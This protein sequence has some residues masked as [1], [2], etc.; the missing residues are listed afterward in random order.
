MEL[1]MEASSS[2]LTDLS[3][4]NV[5]KRI[6]AASHKPQGAADARI[7]Q[8][9][10]D[11]LYYFYEATLL[12]RMLGSKAPHHSANHTAGKRSSSPWHKFLDEFS[13]LGDSELGGSS[14]IAI[15]VEEKVTGLHFWVA[16]NGHVKTKTFD[17]LTWLLEQLQKVEQTPHWNQ[18]YLVQQIFACSIDQ[19][20]KKVCNYARRLLKLVTRVQAAGTDDLSNSGEF[21]YIVCYKVVHALTSCRDRELFSTLEQLVAVH[22]DPLRLCANAYQLRRT[23]SMVQLSDKCLRDGDFSDWSLIRHYV[24]R[25]GSWMKAARTVVSFARQAPDVFRELQIEAVPNP[26]PSVIRWT[27]QLS[28]VEGVLQYLFPAFKSSPPGQSFKP[29]A[30]SY[31]EFVT[32]TLRYK[33]DQVEFRP[34]VH[35][36]AL[37]ADHFYRHDLRFVN[38]DRYIGCRQ[39][40][41][42]PC[43]GNTWIKW[44][45]PY[46]GDIGA[47]NSSL[48]SAQTLTHMMSDIGDDIRKRIMAGGE[49]GRRLPDSVT[50]LSTSITHSN[51]P[52]GGNALSRPVEGVL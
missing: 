42:R 22:A 19:S 39:F 51:E 48:I 37:I 6:L 40:V 18:Q 1:L 3:P 5:S 15:A 13:W 23:Q 35:A 47:R 24:G 20:R 9:S 38:Q 12:L 4:S 45:P 33:G 32:R 11:S 14:V 7:F 8:A 28:T 52:D 21:N 26:L 2:P 34:K 10:E 16:S 46:F 44:Q 30:E 17:H 31:Q 49:T 29:L 43:H 27:R 25:L 36:E 41:E 50:G